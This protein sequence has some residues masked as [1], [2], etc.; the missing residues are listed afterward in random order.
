MCREAI[1]GNLTLR[2]L[3]RDDCADA[4]DAFL[5]GRFGKQGDGDVR[6]DV[7]GADVARGCA[8]GFQIG[9]Y[10]VDVALYGV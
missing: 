10:G 3:R 9:G 2:G 7:V 1:A 8:V 4:D 5:L 6:F